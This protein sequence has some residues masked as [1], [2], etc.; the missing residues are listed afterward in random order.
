M[1]HISETKAKHLLLVNFKEL[2][3]NIIIVIMAVLVSM[4][5][6]VCSRLKESIY[7]FLDFWI[8]YMITENEIFKIYMYEDWIT[9]DELDTYGKNI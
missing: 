2:F 1:F 3:G 9:L 7:D 5:M 8:E 6:L 4:Y